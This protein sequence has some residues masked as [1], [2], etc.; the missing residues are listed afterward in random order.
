MRPLSTLDWIHQEFKKSYHNVEMAFVDNVSSN[1]RGNCIHLSIVRGYVPSLFW[2]F[3]LSDDHHWPSLATCI[4]LVICRFAQI[5]L[6]WRAYSP[7][8]AS[9]IRRNFW[10]GSLVQSAGVDLEILG[11]KFPLFGYV[12]D[13]ESQ[14]RCAECIDYLKYLP[15]WKVKNGHMNKGEM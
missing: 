11:L 6:L 9:R 10:K 1:S 13:L 8:F 3:I 15:T 14:P 7:Q 5:L 12:Q 4:R 2:Y